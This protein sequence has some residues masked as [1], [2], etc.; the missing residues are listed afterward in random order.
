MRALHFQRVVGSGAFGAVYLCDLVAD[1]GFRRQVAVKVLQQDHPNSQMFMSRV[2]DEARLLGLLQDD[3]IL[4]VLE[5]VAVDG[6]DAVVMEFVEGLDLAVLI[7]AKHRPPARA[8]AEL[9]GAIAGALHRAHTAVHPTTG[10]PLNVIHRDVKPANVMVTLRGGVKLLDF[11]AARARFEARE[12]HTGQFVLGTLNYMAPEYIVTGEVSPA[13]DVYG[14]ALVIWEAATGEIYGQPR[15][16]L[17][18]HDARRH[19]H[20]GRLL[21][22][23]EP[24]VPLLGRML[25][26]EPLNRPDTS[27]VEQE[28]VALADAMRGSGL[29]AWCASVV[30]AMLAQRAP[31]ADENG[32]VGR[33]VQLAETPGDEPSDRLG[34]ALTPP[35][36][37]AP[38]DPPNTMAALGRPFPAGGGAPAPTRVPVPEGEISQATPSPRPASAPGAPP[39]PPGPAPVG[40]RRTTPR[41]ASTAMLII[42]GLIVGVSLGLLVLL[43]LLLVFLLWGYL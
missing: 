13:A 8:L 11:G 14:L 15:L 23:Y 18:Q 3:H 27:V 29:R 26:W 41:G 6:R 20:L 9:G 40:S 22:E 16:K 36:P 7:E 30:P 39:P 37:A 42:Q 38:P 2:R 24:L 34:P 35:A 25:E 19:A 10:V 32:L 17:E 1:K 33:Q 43:I 12:S 21:P 28:L 5:I 31:G 4:K